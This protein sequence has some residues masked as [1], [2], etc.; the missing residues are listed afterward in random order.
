MSLFFVGTTFWLLFLAV[1]LDS[2]RLC[3]LEHPTPMSLF[4]SEETKR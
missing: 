4:H 3:F 1:F 2:M